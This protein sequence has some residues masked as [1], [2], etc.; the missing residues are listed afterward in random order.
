MKNMYHD[1]SII[2]P[3]L[4]TKKELKFAEKTIPAIINLNPHEIIF[5]IDAPEDQI[6]VS[7]LN[8]ICNENGFNRQQY[9]TT[10]HNKNWNMPLCHIMWDCINACKNDKTL[11]V[12]VDSLVLAPIM[13]GFDVVGTLNIAAH[14]SPAIHYVKT[15]RD[16]IKVYCYKLFMNK[17]SDAWS[18]VF[19]IYKPYFFEC[20]DPENY[21]KIYNGSDTFIVDSIKKNKKYKYIHSRKF[22]NQSLDYENNDL[23][24]SQFSK[25]IHWYA[26]SRDAIQV[27]S[28]LIKYVLKLL[29]KFPR[30]GIR[31]YSFLFKYPYLFKGYQWASKHKDH[32]IVQ[33]ARKNSS[34]EWSY[35][36]STLINDIYDWEEVS[37]LGT[38][39]TKK[40]TQ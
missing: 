11:I 12:N 14:T 37:R 1:F 29:H 3:I 27:D 25:G 20:V 39:F 24:W 30:I 36:G 35:Y 34:F 33:I 40:Y 26:N 18:G 32:K 9:V 4:G 16:R 31:L 19:W 8:K 13:T 38:G 21:C 15:I 23:Y 22:S 5:G 10:K 7:T 6:L 28:R 2:M 17:M